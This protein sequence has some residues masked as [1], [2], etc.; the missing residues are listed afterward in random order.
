MTPMRAP[1]VAALVVAACG[2]PAARRTQSAPPERSSAALPPSVP[3]APFVVIRNVATRLLVDEGT[4]IDIDAVL[5]AQAPGAYVVTRTGPDSAARVNVEVPATAPVTLVDQPCRH[6]EGTV[7]G[8]TAGRPIY[9]YPWREPITIHA[10]T[11]DEHGRF[12]ACLPPDRY[13]AAIEDERLVSSPAVVDDGGTI[14]FA[15]YARAEAD[16]APGASERVRA[17]SAE[18]LIAAVPRGVRVIGVGEPDHGGRSYLAARAALIMAAARADRL[19]AVVLEAGTSETFPLDQYVLGEDVDVRGPVAKIGFWIWDTEEFLAFLAQLRAYNLA[20]PARP[21]RVYGADVQSSTAAVEYLL[22]HR[23]AAGLAAADAELLAPLAADRG[24]GFAALP[25]ETRARITA[26]LDGVWVRHRASG[27][28]V[29]QR[30]AFAALQLQHRL[31]GALAVELW[32]KQTREAGMAALTAEVAAL[33]PDRTVIYLAHNMHVDGSPLGL[34][35]PA[36]GVLRG[37]LGAGYFTIGVFAAGGVT[38]AWD[39]D[40]AEG[41]LPR[42]LPPLPPGTLEQ[43][44]LAGADGAPAAW[45]RIDALPAAL[46]AWLATPRRVREFGPVYPGEDGAVRYYAVREAFDAAVVVRTVEPTT[47]T[48]T[49]VRM[50]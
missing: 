18:E 32:R 13:V 41:V 28:R 7:V 31:H 49:G 1:L 23:D 20:H 35:V 12:A 22:A 15:T 24:N 9:F 6:V 46:R 4:A 38:R 21:I 5:K 48:P 36:G 8:P 26:A 3:A 43:A 50:K 30:A 11:V 45:V 16:R 14:T 44:I 42:A 33:E 29:A 37:Q 25:E 47:P 2:P 17:G 39:A 27:D 10:T 34:V 40:A 19:S